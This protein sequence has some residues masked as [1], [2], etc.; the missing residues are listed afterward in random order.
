MPQPYEL[1]LVRVRLRESYDFR[2]CIVIDKTRNTI[3]CV[4]LVSSSDLYRPHQDFLIRAD[5]P[6]FPATGLKKTSFAMGDQI[7]DLPAIT[8][9]EKIGELEG[10][11]KV[12]FE[13]WLG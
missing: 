10:G 4:M 3:S 9:D 11:L 1:Y 6:D 13:K 8:L 5:H 2:P 12:E 7:R